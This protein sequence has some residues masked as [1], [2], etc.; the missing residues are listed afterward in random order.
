MEKHTLP[1]GN[2]QT[3]GSARF[4]EKI[5]CEVRP[6]IGKSGVIVIIM[7]VKEAAKVVEKSMRKWR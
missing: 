7:R 2:R 1:E 6:A 5:N 3:A 4:C